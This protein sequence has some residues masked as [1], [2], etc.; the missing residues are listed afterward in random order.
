[1]RTALATL[2]GSSK[3]NEDFV[4]VTDGLVAVLDG[5]TTPGHLDT[6]CSHG[7]RW[8]SH[9][10]GAE[11]MQ[12]LI[13]EPELG[14]ADGLAAAIE[15]LAGRH[16]ATCDIAR[17]ATAPAGSGSPRSNRRPPTKGCRGRSIDRRC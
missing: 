4:A 12:R 9:A 11:I 2:P 16:A 13:T 7:T 6:G 3:P 15:S 5:A 14:L 8:F 10:L 17:T 1:M